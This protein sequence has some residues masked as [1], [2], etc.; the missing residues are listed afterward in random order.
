[1]VLLGGIGDGPH[2]PDCSTHS[3]QIGSR[4]AQRCEVSN[5]ALDRDSEVDQI[6][7][8]A[9]LVAEPPTPGLGR[10]R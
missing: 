1:M 6:V 4:T 7:E 9:T 8:F 10:L 2:L 5:A 3:R